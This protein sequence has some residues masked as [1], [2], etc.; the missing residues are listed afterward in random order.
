MSPADEWQVSRESLFKEFTGSVFIPRG[1]MDKTLARLNEIVAF[2]ENK[3]T[4]QFN[5]Q[6]YISDQYNFL[7]EFIPENIFRKITETL[8][9]TGT[10]KK[11]I[12]RDISLNVDTLASILSLWQL[13]LLATGNY[14]PERVLNEINSQLK[15]ASTY[16]EFRH[17]GHITI[18]DIERAESRILRQLYQEINRSADSTTKTASSSTKVPERVLNYYRQF[19]INIDEHLI[20]RQRKLQEKNLFYSFMSIY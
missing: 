2:S 14:V 18:K 1:K 6:S 15:E 4:K 3:D 13:E 10:G 20:E 5:K 19:M 11:K 9:F 7:Q 16:S 17:K 8:A 12:A